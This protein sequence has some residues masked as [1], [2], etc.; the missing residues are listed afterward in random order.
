MSA[1]PP[2]AVPDNS[3]SHR[4]IEQEWNYPITQVLLPRKNNAVQIDHLLPGQKVIIRYKVSVNYGRCYVGVKNLPAA[5]GREAFFIK[6][7]WI[8]TDDYSRG[9]L[10]I[11][12]SVEG[13]YVVFAELLHFNGSINIDAQI[14][15][16]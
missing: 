4:V 2:Q 10:E 6:G 3:A 1:R 9:Q 14:I 5:N 15:G 16:P 12:I 13:N 7:K 8:T 11:P